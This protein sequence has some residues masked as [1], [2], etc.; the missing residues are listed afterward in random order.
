M[1][2]VKIGI[3]IE[4]PLAAHLL[5]SAHAAAAQYAETVISVK[6]RFSQDGH[7]LKRGLVSY[8]FQSHE[9]HSPLQLT[10]LILRAVLAAHG[11]RKLAQALAQV[12]AFIFPVAK[13]ATGG[14]IGQCQEHLQGISSHLLKLLCSGFYHHPLFCMGI[15]SGR[16]IIQA[17]YR[18]NAKLARADGLQVRVV[19]E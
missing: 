12:T 18:Y 9:L 15:A 19:A 4:N 17:F 11:D 3:A 1:H 13:Q 16:I 8:V 6:E 7:I 14:M 5:A 10:L 2:A